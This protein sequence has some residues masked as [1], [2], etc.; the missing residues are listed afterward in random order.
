MGALS[1]TIP[2]VER[3]RIAVFASGSG[4]NAEAVIR[5]FAQSPHGQ[6]VVVICNRPQAGVIARAKALG[7]PVELISGG[8]SPADQAE[9]LDILAE[10]NV[11]LIALL[12]YLRRVPES[13]IQAFPHR[14]VN[15]H[16][17]LLPK[18]GG[19]GMYGAHV[20]NAVLAAGEP[21]SGI[22]LHYADADYDTGELI[23]QARTPVLPGW[24]ADDLAAAIHTLEH[25]HVPEVLDKICRELAA[26]TP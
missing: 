11:S 21:E 13:V 18:F 4:T 12:G 14:I 26:Q 20:H 7:V 15:L 8:N 16:P 22:S 10:H 25:Q 6:V 3:V 5:H 2:A 1:D 24:S 23:F 9:L 19:P 17:A